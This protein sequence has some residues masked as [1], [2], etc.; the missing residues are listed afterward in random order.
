[1]ADIGRAATVSDLITAVQTAGK[2]APG[3]VLAFRG[4]QNHQWKLEPGILRPPQKLL[5]H[6]RELSRD[7]MAI[8]PQ[9]F[10]GDQ[11]MFDRLV[12]MQHFGM[13]TRL[14]DVSLN[15]LVALYFAAQK[16]Q[17]AG[18][19]VDG[20][21]W[22]LR[23]PPS[24]RKY[25]DSDAVSC[26]ANLANLSS[27]EKQ[28]IRNADPAF[29]KEMFNTEVDAVDK[30]L[31]FIRAEKPYFRPQID[32]EDFFKRYFVSPKMSNRRI[33]A[34]AGAFVIF[35]FDL[36]P[37]S[38]KK[39]DPIKVDRIVVPEGAKGDIRAELDALGINESTLFPEL[40]RAA[41]YIMRRYSN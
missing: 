5:E 31:Q 41:T 2:P 29:S 33:I 38:P 36:E 40:D 25:F 37:G 1:M 39:S 34:Q 8:H 15:P 14:L 23:T 35:G 18:R 7:L 26:L 27:A 3:G 19:P 21:V 17:S 10:A 28:E 16:A 12:R 20:A 24:R 13:R 30:L 11:S 9:E 4:Q 32:R 6:E 22:L